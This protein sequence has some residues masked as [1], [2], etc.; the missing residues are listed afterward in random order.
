MVARYTRRL[1]GGLS[2]SAGL[3]FGLFFEALPPFL[4]GA[5][6]SLTTIGLL[7]LL[8]L[9]WIGKP[10]WAPWM[11][12]SG[13]PAAWFAVA[14]GGLTLSLLG[15]AALAPAPQPGP[16][17]ACLLLLALSAATQDL[18][19]DTTFVGQ[20]RAAG[21]GQGE[22][23]ELSAVRMAA[24][25]AGVLGGSGAVVAGG[26]AYGWRTG[27]AGAAV[28]AGLG[29]AYLTGA[30]RRLRAHAGA[31][32]EGA[33]AHPEDWRAFGRELAAWLRAPGMARVL[34]FVFLYKATL[35]CLGPMSK[36]FWLEQG[37]GPFELG[38][39]VGSVGLTGALMGSALAAY[40]MGRFGLLACLL[41]GSAL[42][43]ITA[44][45]YLAA[46]LGL[47]EGLLGPCVWLEGL[48]QGATTTLLMA[49]IARL[50]D[51]RQAATQFALLAAAFGTARLAGGP[52]SAALAVS[53][54]WTGFA[55]L[56]PWLG[57]PALALLPALG[58]RL[59]Q[60]VPPAAAP[61]A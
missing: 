16:L 8:Q 11:D 6:S 46:R 56:T 12:R 49:L 17:A 18:V 3:P 20:T 14:S 10:L 35:S 47:G 38:A 40:A 28:V 1:I 30:L 48:A 25:K 61:A 19:I 34:A 52:V 33:A 55:A 36:P 45:A 29:G 59:A 5:G 22:L 57:L 23:G 7:S 27:F 50:C 58:R 21:L 53:L 44:F 31:P 4:H 60:K 32:G 26:A 24:Y 43:S 54:G 37:V 51:T 2:L 9:P 42:E 13:R 15:L 39:M 41:L